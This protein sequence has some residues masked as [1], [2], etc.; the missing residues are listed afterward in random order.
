M[1]LSHLL[2]QW[3]ALSSLDSVAAAPVEYDAI[4]SPRQL[5]EPTCGCLRVM[6]RVLGSRTT[7]A[8]TL[9]AQPSP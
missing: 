3:L 9:I 6:V 1:K 5:S 2:L 8:L 4:T 7:L